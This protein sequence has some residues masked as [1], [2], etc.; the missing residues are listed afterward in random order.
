[1]K[2]C[3]VWW[4]KVFA[5]AKKILTKRKKDLEALAQGL[6]EFETLTGSEI[7][8]LLSGKQP[9]RDLGDDTPPSRGSAVPKSG[10]KT[11]KGKKGDATGGHGASTVLVERL[12]LLPIEK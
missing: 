1:M 10:T 6:L 8:D 2:R 4:T 9:A 11:P 12:Q 7:D 5:W 3:V